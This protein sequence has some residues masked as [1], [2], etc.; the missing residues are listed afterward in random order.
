MV[1]W[2]WKRRMT[3]KWSLLSSFLTC[4]SLIG[5]FIETHCHFNLRVVFM[6]RNKI[7]PMARQAF[8]TTPLNLGN[9]E[10]YLIGCRWHPFMFNRAGPALHQELAM[11][12]DARSGHVQT[13]RIR[14][15]PLS[16][17][18]WVSN[19]SASVGLDIA[20]SRK[21]LLQETEKFRSK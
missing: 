14:R 16:P 7:I 8:P 15:P 5:G 3:V 6:Q 4:P 2:L 11:D 20:F 13:E 18:T 21:S 12:L 9:I 1:R 17:S 10:A 19:N